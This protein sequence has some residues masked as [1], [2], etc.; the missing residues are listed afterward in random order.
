MFF[1]IN[2]QSLATFKYHDLSSNIWHVDTQLSFYDFICITGS[3]KKK[4]Q[5]IC[6]DNETGFGSNEMQISTKRKPWR[7]N[8]DGNR[9][10]IN[11]SCQVKVPDENI[12]D[13]NKQNYQ[14]NK[15]G[16]L[17][18]VNLKKQILWFFK[19]MD[20]LYRWTLGVCYALC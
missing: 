9:R 15:N 2:W 14:T 13:E 20:P 7:N 3:I 8:Y 18:I 6:K 16:D 12:A 10:E 1:T 5:K 19:K 11:L 17:I 4:F